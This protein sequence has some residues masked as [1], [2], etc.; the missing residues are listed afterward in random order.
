[1]VKKEKTAGNILEARNLTKSFYLKKRELQVLRGINLTVGRGEKVII[2]GKSGA[3]KSTL[4]HMLAGLERPNLSSGEII[5]DGKVINKLSHEELA[6]LRQKKVGIVFQNFNLLPSWSVCENVEATLF[7]SGLERDIRKKK[8]VDLLT[9]VGLGE[10][11]DNMPAELSIGQQ[12][13]VALARALVNEPEMIF[14]DEP[15]GDVDK[16][17]ANKIMK[18]LFSWIKERNT[19]LLI[20]THGELIPVITADRVLYLQDGV[21]Q[22]R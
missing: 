1:M 5:F 6:K 8:A 2:S 7:F 18:V 4:L 17:T 19:T 16:E 9:R 13:R 3:G 21:L 11:L 20:V 15:T 14:A 22:P 12:Q 10:R